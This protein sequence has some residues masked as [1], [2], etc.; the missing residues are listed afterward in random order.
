MSLGI[1]PVKFYSW[2]NK[3]N[4]IRRN[5]KMMLRMEPLKSHTL[6]GATYV[7]VSHRTKGRTI[8][9]VMGGGGGIFSLHE[10]FFFAHCLCRNCFFR[11]IFFSDK[12]CFFWTVKSW[13]II[14]VFVL[15]KLFYT[16]NRSK[17][18]GHFNAKS[19]RKCT[20]SERGGSHLEWTA[21]LC[22]FSVPALWNSSPT[23]HHNDAI[24]HS[25]MK[26]IL[27]GS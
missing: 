3:R 17:D 26:T 12:Y 13:F 20:H 11:R 4:P 7:G 5:A 6:S 25:P 22:I 18:T 16:H 19:F 23:A 8:R 9:K 14:Y 27:C 2:K 10:F 1:Y 21:S 15:Y 24:L